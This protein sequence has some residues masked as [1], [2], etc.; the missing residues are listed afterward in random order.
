MRMN[1]KLTT[2]GWAV[3]AGV[4]ATVG[5]GCEDDEDVAGASVTTK[6]D[7]GVD[8]PVMACVDA[9]P[10][11][12]AGDMAPATPPDPL[13]TAMAEAIAAGRQSFRSDTFGSEAFWGDTLKLHQAIAGA[14]NGGVGAGLSPKAALAAGLK[15]DAEALPAAL[16]AQVQAGQVNLD[17]PATTLA[18][19]QLNAVVG[20]TG[21]FNPDKTIKSIGIQCAFCHSTVD[22]SFMPGIGKRLDGWANRDL[23]VGAVI[24][25]APDLTIFTT[26]LGVDLPTLKTVLAAWG[27]GKFDA[28]LLLDGKALRPDGKPGATLIPPA[29][30][31]AGQSLH[32]WTGW[33]SV[34]HW[35]ALV[36]N[37]E[38]GG[39]GTFFDPRLNDAAKFP[40]AA[41]NMFGNVR[42]TPDLITAKLAD[43]QIYQLALK[44]PAPKAGSFDPAASERGKALFAGKAKCATC[45]VPPLFTEPGW[46]MHTAAEIGI[47]DF[48]SS[49]SPDN[50]YRT[51]PLR[52]LHS[53]S[54]GG[55]YHDGRFATMAD[56]VNHYDT[57]L[58]LGLTAAEKTDLVEYLKSL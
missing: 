45:H 29:F 57:F 38:M 24:A 46:P 47:D 23:N 7:G 26:L 39:K 25:M 14:A 11:A 22:D 32:T 41:K 18:L 6:S 54:K 50:R 21:I 13:V 49:R 42:K 56:V 4:L 19:L 5:A 2:V 40:I 52:G 27:P 58:T 8:A 30:G 28:E 17:D 9:A 51:A 43:L 53:H 36:A 10:S 20:V 44:A 55:F 31:L 1:G 48:Q 15:V 12:S 37:L 16:V 3:L 35:N 33:G 34:S